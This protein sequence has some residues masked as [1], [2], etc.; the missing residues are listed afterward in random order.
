MKSAYELALERLKASD[1]DA[2]TTLTEKQKKELAEIDR[3]YKAKIAEKEIFLNN[4]LQEA[5]AAGRHEDA[6]Q[7]DQ[8]LRNEKARLKEESEDAREKVRR[9][10]K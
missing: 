3:R 9:K 10:S 8:Q 7:I 1:P 2:V 6:E 5:L 4:Q